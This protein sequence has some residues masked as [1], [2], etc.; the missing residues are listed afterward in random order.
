MFTSVKHIYNELIPSMVNKT[1]KHHFL[2]T[3]VKAT[4][5]PKP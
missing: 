4:I 3:I 5:S 1:M 2:H